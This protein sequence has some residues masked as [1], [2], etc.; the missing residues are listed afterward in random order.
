[1]RGHDPPHVLVDARLDVPGEQGL[2]QLLE[3]GQRFAAQIPTRPLQQVR[4]LHPPEPVPKCGLDG[5]GQFTEAG[6]PMPDSMAQVHGGGE[7]LDERAVQIEER[8]DVR[9][10]GSGGD[11]RA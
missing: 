3:F 10:G 7:T 4:E 2:A 5:A 1:M 11:L 9:A 8:A 6:L